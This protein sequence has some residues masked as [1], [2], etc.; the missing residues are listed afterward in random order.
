MAEVLPVDVIGRRALVVDLFGRVVGF[1]L[2]FLILGDLKAIFGDALLDDVG[3]VSNPAD[4]TSTEKA[5]FHGVLHGGAVVGVV[6][7]FVV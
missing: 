1:V 5:V 7:Q 2:G 4:A 3:L 6:F